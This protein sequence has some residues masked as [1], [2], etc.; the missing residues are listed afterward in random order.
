MPPLMLSDCQLCLDAELL[1]DDVQPTG[2]SIDTR[3]IQPGDLYI[4]IKGDRFDGHDYCQAAQDAGACGFLVQQAIDSSLPQ[5]VVDDTR[6]ALGLLGKMWAEQFQVPTVAVTGSNGKTTVKEMIS[7]ILSQLGPVLSTNANF[8]ND[9]GVPLTLLRLREHHQY[10]VIEIGANHVGEVAVLTRLV[11]PDV[12]LVNNVGEAHLEG[13]GSIEAVAQA[14][15]EIFQGLS[16]NGWAVINDDDR[17]AD[18]MRLAAEKSHSH[19]F[20]T[21]ADVSV[22]LLPEDTL[23]IA[24]GDKTLSPRFKLLGRHNRL[25]AVAATAV[26]QCMDVQPVAIM[27]GLA[28]IEPVAGR[29]C[30]KVGINGATL[31][32]DTYNANPVSVRAAIDVLAEFSGKRILVLGDL[33][34]LGEDEQSMHA[35]LGA[36]AQTAG[37]E[38]LYTVGVLSV[39]AANAFNGA[40]HFDSQEY[41]VSQLRSDMNHD[42]TVL[43]KGSRGSRME[44]VVNPLIESNP[45]ESQFSEI[46]AADTS[47]VISL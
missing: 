40:Q 26:A 39:N 38:Q 13:F 44:R 3:T 15:S 10:A 33:G 5:L 18:V 12:A 2:F 6:I 22:R 32:D 16:S 24:I 21:A 14:K 1:G 11:Q 23:Q 7:A 29:L 31:I 8:N 34:E 27:S 28:T 41:I 45:R 9:I 20:G 17:F 42:V 43:V 19:E 37:I 25:N 4:A 47:E 36:Y 30:T 46:D 35:E